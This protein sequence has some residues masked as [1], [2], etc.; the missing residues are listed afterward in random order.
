LADNIK[1][2]DKLI[3]L[4]SSIII[5]IN[6]HTSNATFPQKQA[7]SYISGLNKKRVSTDKLY[8]NMINMYRIN[9]TTGV[10]YLEGIYLTSGIR[11]IF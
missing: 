10:D 11:S 2:S 8:G 9:D 4:E 3:I 6:Y 1:I 7:I 5:F